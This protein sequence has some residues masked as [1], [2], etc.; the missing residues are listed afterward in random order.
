[1][2]VIQRRDAIDGMNQD[3][4]HNRCFYTSYS[5]MNEVLNRFASEAELDNI[6]MSA[7]VQD[8]KKIGWE[9]G[10]VRLSV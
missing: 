3:Q 6:W 10:F 5:E 8:L 7:E 9:I 4:R 2:A 1:M